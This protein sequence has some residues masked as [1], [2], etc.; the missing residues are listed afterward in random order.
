MFKHQNKLS[1]TNIWQVGGE[2]CKNDRGSSILIRCV[3][4]C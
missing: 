3:L 1:Y 4:L 2:V